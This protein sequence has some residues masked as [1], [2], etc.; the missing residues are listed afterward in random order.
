MAAKKRLIDEHLQAAHAH[1]RLQK[2]DAL[3]AALAILCLL[4]VTS[5]GRDD[6]VRNTD[7][8][9]VRGIRYYLPKFGKAVDAFLGIP[10]AKPPTKHLRFRHPEPIEQWTGIRNATKLPNSCYQVP[11]KFF[12]DFYGSDVWNPTTRVSE[13]C[14]YINV[15]VP[16]TH[17]RIR[18][19]AVMVWIYGGGFYSGTTTLNLYDGKILAAENEV[20]VV[21][22]GYRVGAL[23]FLT[24]GHP[25]APGN[26]GLFDQLMG[27]EWVHNNIRNFGGD[28][29]N[30]TL[31]GESAGSVSVSLH[32][33]SP[34]SR[35]KFQR[36]ILQSGSANTAWAT[37]TLD[38][39]RR[40]SLELAFSYLG[41][42]ETDDMDA[43]AECLRKIG[44]QTLVEDQWVS[45]G[46]MQFPFL[47]VID[48]TFLTES[49][50]K[51]LERKSF[52]R[53]PILIGSNKNEG[54]WF[55]IYELTEFISLET[56]SMSR[57]EFIFS[58]NHLF[59]YYPQYPQ[60]NNRFG[61]DAVI[62]HYSN[63][64]DPEDVDSNL[65]ALD[66]AVGDNHLVCPLNEF[67]HAY[68]SAGENVYM[69]Y[70][71][72]RYSTNPWPPWMGDVSNSSSDILI[73]DGPVCFENDPNRIPGAHSL[74]EWPLHT[75][76]GREYL[77]INTKYLNEPDKSKAIGR[78]PKAKNCAFW[79][80]Y[81]PKLVGGTCEYCVTW[82]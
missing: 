3:L 32:L 17:P 2:S 77:E 13:D 74:D 23:G 30:I 51:S 82:L 59:F 5:S 4:P 34:L 76:Q 81:L 72:Q 46:V 26:S 78:G 39:G 48:G 10:F 12:G 20:I 14:L 18:K 68:A 79:R 60:V 33:L 54:A 62:F 55:I 36:A 43:V 56:K 19:S 65:H 27:L 37:V 8:G 45:R 21:S 61:L 35:N 75:P 80:E 9:R 73:D 7:K 40:R 67:A 29:D 15:W 24:L 57:E 50:M 6:L 44:P 70:L 52:K 42:K 1:V 69:Y 64:L 16:R 63:F 22:I 71:T 38:E 58:M 41:C 53:C 31:F 47:P 25:T 49:P 28:P 11:D 66:S